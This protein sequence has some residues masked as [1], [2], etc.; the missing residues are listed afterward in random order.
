LDEVEVAR[1]G[2]PPVDAIGRT[3]I[4]DPFMRRRAPPSTERPD[5][6]VSMFLF[7]GIGYSISRCS[8]GILSA[9]RCNISDLEAVCGQ[10]AKKFLEISILFAG[11]FFAERTTRVAA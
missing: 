9:V 4:P 1:L 10:N 5:S 11:R 8:Q 2:T 3:R 6:V 7:A